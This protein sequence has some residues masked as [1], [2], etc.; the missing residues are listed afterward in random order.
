MKYKICFKCKIVKELK[1]FTTA[2]NN[3]DGKTGTCKQCRARY[4]RE[5][6][7]LKG[8]SSANR[9]PKGFFENKRD[10]H[11]FYTYNLRLY[12]FNNILQAQN[13]RC[14]ICKEL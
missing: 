10:K 8:I 9:K 7:I 4:Q 3:K 6:K 5:L 2:K 13:N 1:H 11:L 12:E 14:K